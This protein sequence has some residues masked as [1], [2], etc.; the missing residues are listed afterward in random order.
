[1]MD[2]SQYG[3]KWLLEIDCSQGGTISIGNDGFSGVESLKCTFD[4]NYPGYEA[5]YMAEF[6]IYNTVLEVVKKVVEE[7][8]KVRFS[9]GYKDGNYGKIFSGRILKSLYSR[10]NVT[11]Y[12]LNLICFDGERLFK[13][14]FVKYNISKYENTTRARLALIAA[15]SYRPIELKEPSELIGK[16]RKGSDYVDGVEC[17]RGESAFCVPSTKLREIM[18]KEGAVMFMID[19]VLHIVK[20][21][22]APIGPAIEIGINNGLIGSPMQ[23]DGGIVFKTLLNPELILDDPLRW[24]K[25]D[26]SQIMIIPKKP[27]IGVLPPPKIPTDGYFKV[28]GVRHTGDT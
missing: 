3:R 26:L 23:T 9:A 12:K 1:M 4:I 17:T 27:V 8:N 15:N 13:D 24:V 18:K 11:D 7:G 19:D 2:T 6:T 14:N 25:L 20:I 5:W 10:E 21:E 22:D 28:G 16:V